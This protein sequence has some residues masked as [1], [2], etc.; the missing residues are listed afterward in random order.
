[1][2]ATIRYTK[3]DNSSE[4]IVRVA[5]IT[6]CQPLRKG[7]TLIHLTN[8]RTIPTAD[9]IEELERRIDAAEEIEHSQNPPD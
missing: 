9:S 6:H 4:G 1:M 7:L 5:E 8:E 2:K 3:T